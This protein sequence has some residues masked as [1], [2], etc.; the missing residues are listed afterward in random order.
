[1]DISVEEIGQV[2]VL[3][4]SGNIV[5]GPESITVN[6]TL[7]N[8]ISDKKVRVILDLSGIDFMN[9]SGLGVIIHSANQLKQNNGSLRLANVSDKIKHIMKITKLDSVFD[10]YESVDAAVKSFN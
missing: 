7:A 4:L 9:S 5:G 3:K 8:L 1:M 2:T 6:Q 10:S